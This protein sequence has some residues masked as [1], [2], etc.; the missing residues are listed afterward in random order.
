LADG[1]GPGGGLCRR[2]SQRLAERVSSKQTQRN[3]LP[4]YFPVGGAKP[5]YFYRKKWRLA[6]R[7]EV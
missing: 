7:K 6:R 2:G 5:R 1:L 4:S 3:S